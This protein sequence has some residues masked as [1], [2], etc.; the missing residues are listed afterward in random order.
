VPSGADLIAAERRRQIA[1]E[2]WTPAHDR[3]HP[4]WV[5]ARATDCYLSVPAGRSEL[6]SPPLGWP[7]DER[8]WKPKGALR[9]MVRA[10]ALYQAAIDTVLARS[11]LGRN[12]M[13]Y[14]GLVQ[15]RDHCAKQIDRLLSEVASVLPAPDGK[16]GDERG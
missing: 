2:G 4:G 3:E 12:D 1:V 13:A 15:G 10:G 6:S 7:W 14:D 9:N 5:L 8:F 16:A 11:T